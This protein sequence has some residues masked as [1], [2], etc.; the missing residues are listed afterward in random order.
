[1]RAAVRRAAGAALALALL[2]A[3]PARAFRPFDSTDASV[4]GEGVLELELGPVAWRYEGGADVLVAPDLVLNWGLPRDFELSLAGRG[5]TPLS[6][7]EDERSA[8]SHTSLTLKRLLRSGSLQ[9]G[10]GPSAAVEV[11]LLLPTLHDETGCGAS[12]VGV[13]SQRWPRL[14][15]HLSGGLAWTRA[16]R[17]AVAG[18]LV[19]EGPAWRGLRPV[20]ELAAGH[21][22]G[23]ETAVSGLVGALWEVRPDL[24]FDAGVRFAREGGV[25]VRELRLGLTV[26]LGRFAPW[27]AVAPAR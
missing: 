1:V 20:A 23:V 2:C 27:S 18:G 22:D 9:E 16:E 25:H 14:T 15:A 12:V 24:V 11:S 10:T 13:V 3:S 26:A 17:V 4:A 19:L 8:I 21:E 7:A 5:L 6:E